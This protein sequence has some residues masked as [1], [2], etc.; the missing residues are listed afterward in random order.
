MHGH[1]N[2]KW[3]ILEVLVTN[4]TVPHL[5]ISVQEG[6]VSCFEHG[7]EKIWGISWTFVLLVA[8]EE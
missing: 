3:K 2:V 7:S 6:V 1:M 5:V 4:H 8:S